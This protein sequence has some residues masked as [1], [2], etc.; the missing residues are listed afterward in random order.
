MIKFFKMLGKDFRLGFKIELGGEFWLEEKEAR[1]LKGFEPRKGKILS[2]CDERGRWFRARVLGKQGQRVRLLVFEELLGAVESGLFLV[3]VQAIPNKERMELIIEKAV[4][5]GVDMIQPVFTFRSYRLCDLPQK[6]WHRWQERARRASEQSRRGV[7]PLVSEPLPLREAVGNFS[8]LE[9]KIVLW[10]KEK[11]LGLKELLQAKKDIQS[12]VLINGPEGGLE[13][14][15]IQFLKRF[16]FVPVSLGARIFRTETS[17]IVSV[18][19]IQFYLG[20]LG[21][22]K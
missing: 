17:A 13:E 5:L 21:R 8:E 18:G 14:A 11:K 9:L 4:E 22:L 15:E 6:K 3:L 20:D 7:V 1:W 10:E 19:L 16:G 12:V 2:I